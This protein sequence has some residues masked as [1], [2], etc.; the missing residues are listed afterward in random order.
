MT[1]PVFPSLRV[2]DHLILGYRRSRLFLLKYLINWWRERKARKNS[3][4]VTDVINET[5]VEMKNEGETR[6]Y[7]TSTCWQVIRKYDYGVRD[8]WGDDI[9]VDYEEKK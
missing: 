2:G 5:L 3:L 8:L 1:V 7:G 9:A 6:L 4:V